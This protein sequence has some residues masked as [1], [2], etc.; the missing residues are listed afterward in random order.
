MAMKDRWGDTYSAAGDTAEILS[1]DE[2]ER[3]RKCEHGRETHRAGGVGG[4][5]RGNVEMEVE[6][7]LGLN[8]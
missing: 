1:G 6:P 7:G 3:R 8:V 4:L 5:S 2:G